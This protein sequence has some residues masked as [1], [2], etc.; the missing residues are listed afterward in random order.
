MTMSSQA[1][2]I[3]LIG[4]GPGCKAVLKLLDRIEMTALR[5][6]VL[7]VADI[8]PES[9]GFQY[10]KK[11]GLLTVANY[12]DFFALPNLDLIIELTGNDEVLNVILRAKPLT[13]KVMDHVAARLFWEIIQIDEQKTMIEQKY[14][15]QRKLSEARN[16]YKVLVENISDIV[17]SLDPK[18]VISYTNPAVRDILGYRPDELTGL[19]FCDILVPEDYEPIK[20]LLADAEGEYCFECRFCSKS[21]KE[22]I[23]Q[24]SGHTMATTGRRVGFSAVA[25]DITQRIRTEQTLIRSNQILK[26]I[27]DLMGDIT[28]NSGYFLNALC[29]KVHEL[30]GGSFVCVLHKDNNEFLLRAFHNLPA[31]LPQLCPEAMDGSLS[32]EVIKTRQVLYVSNLKESPYRDHDIVAKNQLT[33]YLGIPLRSSTGEMIG[34]LEFYD[35][36]EHIFSDEDIKLFEILAE[37]AG[38]ELENIRR[39]REKEALQE[40]LFQAQKMEAIGT[41]AGGIAHDFNNLLGGILGYA[42]YGK[43]LLPENHTVYRHLEVIETSAER[44][45]QLVQQMLGFSRGGKYEVKRVNCNMVVEEVVKLL[46]RTIDKSISIETRLCPDLAPVLADMVQIQQVALNMCINARDAMPHGGRLLLET[47]NVRLDQVYARKHLG[48]V[49]GEYVL[50]SISDTGTGMDPEVKKRIFEPFFTTKEKG[51]GTGLGLA[52]VYGIVKNHGGYVNFY[53]EK[54]MGTRF[55]VYLPVAEEGAD[56]IPAARQ[57]TMPGG[58]ETILLI[59]DE[60]VIRDLGKEVLETLGYNVLVAIDGAEALE[61]YERD[62]ARI[63]LVILDIVMPRVGGKKTFAALKTI[64]PSVRVILSSG[65]SINGEAQDIL[66]AGAQAFIQKPYRIDELSAVIRRVL[67][68]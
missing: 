28:R 25:R 54:D 42:S 46:S 62:K 53:S 14:L 44:A 55:N 35:H 27:H 47:E 57:K 31:E 7:G 17:F 29:A 9:P 50:M 23:M 8:N 59:D 24:V 38:F 19:H 49:P 56:D 52:M 33:A 3:A 18:G 63:D 34:V 1:V 13:V 68:R 26:A 60:E 51:K 43:M 37:R 64:Q 4:G 2:N 41:L 6:N 58:K 48:A 15:T 39:Q 12:H 20:D 67:D 40:Q 10:A 16:R 61:I 66:S 21:G 5:V 45:A 32:S 22:R 36:A 11:R 65:Y 30:F